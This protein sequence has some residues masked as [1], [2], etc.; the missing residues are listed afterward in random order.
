MMAAPGTKAAVGGAMPQGSLFAGAGWLAASKA[1]SQ[2]FSWIGTLYVASRLSPE[3][4]G[5]SNLST[6]FTEF[7]VILTNTG[8]GTTLIQRQDRNH[9]RADSLFTMTL[10]LGLLLAAC[11]FGLAYFGAWYFQNP[12]LIPLTQFTAIIYVLSTLAI[13]PYNYLNRDMRFK[14]RGLLDMYSVWASISVQ[15]VLA[16]LGFGVWTLLWGLA[17]RAFVRL[18]LAFRYSG[19][20]PRLGFDWELIRGDI[21]FS[22]QLTFNW[23]LY[24]LKE[25]CVP[26]IIGR[27]QSVAQL[28]LLGFAGSLAA[29]PNLKVVQLLREVLLPL[30]ARRSDPAEQLQGLG[31]A[32]KGMAL[33]VA[34]LYLAGY[35]YGDAV[36]RHVLPPKWEP[37]FPLFQVLCLVQLWNVL[38]SIVSIY[39]TAQGRPVRSTWF[40]LP[41]ALLIPAA[42]WLL[43]SAD[44][45]LMALVWSAL[46]A[47]V[48]LLWFLLLFR[49]EARFI[50]GFL[51]SLAAV[52]AVCAAAFLVDSLAA[53]RFL[54]ADTLA[55]TALRIA[56]FALLYGA[57]LRAFHWPFL[58]SLRRK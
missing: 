33:F 40:D 8:I 37:M 42:T 19:Y 21:G 34:P 58:K 6:A 51:G 16:A 30:L 11:A 44:L 29:I 26:I 32:L 14:E 9:V 1:G 31:T 39:N 53:S 7:A 27:T 47:G 55:G 20:R 2:A 24:A 56:G 4:Y 50:G 49:R 41:M 28:G 57:F 43:R 48:F 36:L 12:A 54:P 5:L 35:Y 17:V 38:S 13:V 46:G 25:R 18:W 52:A 15:I 45:R 3:D 10:G 23:F 22:A